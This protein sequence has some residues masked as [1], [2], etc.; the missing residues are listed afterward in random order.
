MVSIMMKTSQPNNNEIDW[1]ALDR[2]WAE[3][4]E[5]DYGNFFSK[6]TSNNHRMSISVSDIKTDMLVSA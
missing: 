1:N 5:E 2:L 4:Y 3:Q 6:R